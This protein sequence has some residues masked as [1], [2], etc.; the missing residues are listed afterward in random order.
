MVG[1]FSLG[2]T[3]AGMKTDKIDDSMRAAILRL[4]TGERECLK[5]CLDHQTAKEMALDLGVSPHAVEKRLK[6]AR[7][8]LGVSSSLEAAKLVAAA[9]ESNRLVPQASGLSGTG[10]IVEEVP[11]AI[12]HPPITRS[13]Q[14]PS[15]YVISGA[16]L[17]ILVAAAALI[18]WL[19][20]S[21]PGGQQAFPPAVANAAPATSAT[22]APIPGTEA[23]LRQLVA[24]LA[25]GSPNY[26]KLSPGFAEV[27]R[28]DLPMTH[29]M[30]KALGELKSVTFR[31]RGMKNDDIY[32][33]VF[34]N[35]EVLMSA[36]L[37]AEGRMAGGI[38]QPGNRIPTS[39]APSPGT[40]AA[41][42]RLVAGLAS[43]SP[44]YDKLAPKF[45]DLVRSD[46]PMSQP[47][48]KSMGELKSI[49]Y[50]GKGRMGDDVYNLVFANGGVLMS[51]FLDAN[52]RMAGGFIAPPSTPLP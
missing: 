48:F 1:T 50:R 14:R 34:T 20:A 42:R 46:M 38:L 6:M 9:D 29:P 47:M 27:V 24:G 26:E 41:V 22:A 35:G 49:T 2:V 4:T 5:R 43:G 30:F 28:R 39:A 52:G 23:V 13:E 17:M 18:V 36:A 25:S 31:S 51:A 37:D 12:P 32:N 3:M 45:G 44:D 21:G 11:A 7:A 8:K 33:L 10:T 16:I 19:Q 15:T 40:E